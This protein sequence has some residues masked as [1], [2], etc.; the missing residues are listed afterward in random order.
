[1]TG[2]ER[3][4]RNEHIIAALA[5][6]NKVRNKSYK[7]VDE[8]GSGGFAVVYEATDTKT[9]NTVVIKAVDSAITD[10]NCSAAEI[11]KYTE[12]EIRALSTCSDCKYIIDIY[13]AFCCNTNDV[14]NE[15]VYLMFLPKLTPVSSYFKT[16]RND[17]NAILKMTMDICKAL[18]WCHKNK[19]LHRDVKNGNIYY[20]E[21]KE[22][23]VLADFGVS[24]VNFDPTR[25]ITVI[26]SYIAPEII[27]NKNLEGRYNSDIFSLGITTLL[28][29]TI[30]NGHSA[31]IL[32]YLKNDVKNDMLRIILAKTIVED[33]AVRYQTADELYEDICKI[34]WSN[35]G[36][37]LKSA[38]VE[39]CVAALLADNHGYAKQIAENGHKSGNVRMSCLYAYILNCQGKSREALSILSGLNR[40]DDPVVSAL[41]GIIGYSSNGNG[42]EVSY[43]RCIQSA[44]EKG[45]SLAEYFVGRWMIDGQAGF[46]KDVEKGLEYIFNACKKGFNPGLVYLK[47]ALIRNDDFEATEAMVALL[48]KGLENYNENDFP[49][50]AI[51]AIGAA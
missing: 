32:E 34:D 35:K 23:F 49:I 16:H 36:E 28:L 43:I 21:K 22:C 2:H 31:N 47:K 44:A 7:I 50:D 6:Y 20:C 29:L 33:P 18:S 9:G 11:V 45:F 14:T 5:L 3:M 19:I 40:M 48:A 38:G 13:D 24:R 30:H 12:A 46:A 15:K 8:I 42:S 41:Y 51:I 37:Y 10:I 39:A 4:A 26:G 1:M 27:K 25:A 17:E